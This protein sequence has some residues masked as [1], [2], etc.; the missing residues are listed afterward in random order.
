MK[1]YKYFLL[2]VVASLC[3][4]GCTSYSTATQTVPVSPATPAPKGSESDL[5][6]NNPNM[7]EAAKKGIMGSQ[8]GQ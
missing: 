4:T 5:I 8:G 7:P 1:L 2:T 6:K 3:V